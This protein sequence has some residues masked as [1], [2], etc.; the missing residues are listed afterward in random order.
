MTVSGA[1]NTPSRKGMQPPAGP[2]RAALIGVENVFIRFDD[3]LV[4]RDINLNIAAGQT[5]AMVGESGCGK[6]V[7]LKLMIGLLRPT[8]GRVTFDGKVLADLGDSDMTRERLRF[9][10]LF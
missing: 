2:P 4:L 7:M 10:F 6:T 3:Q 9:G 5:I 8:S 1:S